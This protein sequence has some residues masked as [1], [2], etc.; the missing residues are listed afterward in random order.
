MTDSPLVAR[1]KRSLRRAIVYHLEADGIRRQRQD[2]L[3]EKL[4]LYQPDV[5]RLLT[6]NLD[7]F[8][9]DV[10]L[11]TTEKLGAEFIYDPK[12]DDEA[13]REY[14]KLLADC[15]KAKSGSAVKTVSAV[16]KALR[17]MKSPVIA[18]RL[19][20]KQRLDAILGDKRD[21]PRQDLDWMTKQLESLIAEMR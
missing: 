16:V 6:G 15:R 13:V 11:R 3:A 7:R 1:V 12:A 18:R 14:E 10:L 2:R 21:T 20:H 8:S 19:N 9:V 17:S 5:S 4:G